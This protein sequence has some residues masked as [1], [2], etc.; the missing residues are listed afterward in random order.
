MNRINL[1]EETNNKSNI[2]LQMQDTSYNIEQKL[3]NLVDSIVMEFTDKRPYLINDTE[4]GKLP[5]KSL[6][7]EILNYVDKNEIQIDNGV[8]RILIKKVKDYLFGYYV[9]QDLIDDDEISDIRVLSYD[10][11]QIKIKGKRLPSTIR[12][13]SKKS[14]DIF[15]NY[16]VIKLNGT[17]DKKNAIQVLSDRTDKFYLRISLSSSF[18]NSVDNSYISIRKIPKR[19]VELESLMLKHNMFNRDIYSYLVKRVKAGVNILLCGKGGS[20]KT[21]MINALLEKVPYDRA[22]LIIQESEELF[23]D[24]PNMMF[25]K[26]KIKTGEN[27]AE[28]SLGDL[29][30]FAMTEDL[31][32]IVIG[33]I[34]GKEALN[35]FKVV[36]TGHDGWGSVH[37]N[38]SKEAVNKLID[39]MQEANPNLSRVSL[40]KLLS[41][42]DIIIFMKDYKVM[43]I[44]EVSNF[45]EQRCEIVFNPIFK[46][47]KGN[48]KKLNDSCNKVKEKIEYANFVNFGGDEI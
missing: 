27:D 43:E 24:H 36:G 41:A 40:L 34:K 18:V 47:Y 1:V 21:T 6:K 8:K 33:E 10:N 11:I 46:F 12:F 38:G 26:E 32:M 15:F 28:Y 7:N 2:S 39:Y 9:L 29:T 31:D 35:L 37:S 19:K 3:I 30:R 23:S 16:I 13:P 17:L 44:T 4:S 25:Q 48:F 42:I 14:L 20:G 45:D 5:D 22:A